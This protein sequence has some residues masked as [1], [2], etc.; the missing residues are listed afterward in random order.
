MNLK[1]A[2]DPS[3]IQLCQRAFVKIFSVFLIFFVTEAA[4]Q[5]PNN[6]SITVTG[7]VTDEMNG[8]LPGV[9]IKVKGSTNSASTDPDGKYVISVPAANSILVFS[10]IGFQT[11]EVNVSG[12]KLINVELKED[13]TSLEEVMVV[14]YGTQKKA[15]LT[16][17]VATVSGP[18]LTQRSAPNAANLLQGR[19]TGVQVTQPS[20]EPGRDNPKFLIRGQSSYG[21][22]SDPLILI[23]GVAGSFNNLSPDDIENVTVLKDAA[24]AAIYGARAA[25]GVV[26][27]TTK[28][29]K[30][31]ETV[32]SYR[33]NLAR[34]NATALP[35]LITNSAQYMEMFNKAADR[36]GVAFKYPAEDIEKYRNPSAQ[37]PS[38]DNIDYYIN[39]ATV[40]SHNLSVSG[41]S[42]KSTFNLSGGYLD[43]DAVFKGYKF[44]RYNTLFNYSNN[45]SKNVTVGTIV[46][47]TYKDR[48]E[49]P[50][51]GENMALLVYAAGPLYG[52]FLNDGSGRVASRAYKGEGRNRN[53]QEVY[54]MGEQTT[55]EYNLNA[56]AYMDVKLFKGFTWSS[57]VAVNY[58]DEYYKMHQ[59]NYKAY[60]SQQIDPNTNDYMVDSFG[61]DILGITNQYS[62]VLNPTIYSMLT[63]ETTFADNHN[64]KALAGYEQLFSSTQSLRGRR[65]NSVAPAISDITGYSPAN[66]SLYFNHPRLPGLVMPSEWGMR[67]FFS[68]VNYDYKGRYLFEANLRYDGTSRVSPDYRWGVFPSFSAGWL[69][70]EEDF[71]KDNFKWLSS[72]KIRGSY[73]TLGNQDIGTYAYQNNIIIDGIYYPFNNAGLN[74][75]GVINEFKDPSLK[76]E[77]TRSIDVGFDMDIKNGL[78]GLTFDWFRKSTSDILS[79]PQVPYSLGLKPSR[80]NDGR[81]RS[82]G[83]ELALTHQNNIGE[84]TYGF[85]ALFST[86]KNKVL[87]ISTPAKGSTINQ[88][89]LPYG[90]FYL[91]QWDGIFQVE[92]IGNPN[93]PEHELNRNPKAGDLKMKDINGDGIV[94]GDDRV[95]IDGV[96]PDFNYSFGFNVGYKRFSLNAFFQGVEGIKNRVNNWGI[97]PFMQGTAPT[98]KW[99]D[100]W[101]PE[102]RSNELPGIYVAGYSGVASYTASTYY[103]QDASYLRLKNVILNYDIPVSKLGKI[104]IKNLGIYVS[105]DN[106][107]TVTKYEGGDPERASST[108]NLAQ[109]PQTKIYNVGLNVK[110]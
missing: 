21:A 101:T 25:N 51:T 76:W 47:M 68:R 15:N 22:G 16:G 90:S 61:P 102:N 49:P 93:V 53:P 106:L 27:V 98:K 12:R 11:Q 107:F 36:S 66:E 54:A 92:D 2:K 59:S 3:P 42:D 58:T 13:Q 18:T 71:M 28:K 31:G 87:E 86:A 109:Y 79:T 81:M 74:Q 78:F 5:Q 17:A 24:S 45:L 72:M 38:F 26:L 40:M 96:Y 62:K 30:K 44:K 65:I 39:P 64:F 75:G 37:Y 73:G 88:A 100:A 67:S 50:F 104:G 56:Q 89:G 34:H 95:V 91:Y 94:N 46:N 14:G 43:Q 110:F 108:G 85:N 103:L 105:A 1:K 82:Q 69:L 4:A 80:V 8:G 35:D 84:V 97:D 55:K 60:L 63:Y 29:G 41:G 7:K 70:S 20:G 10:Y 99:E 6:S 77:T 23:D 9:S 48:K 32:I 83:I 52:P 57:K 19:I 33:T